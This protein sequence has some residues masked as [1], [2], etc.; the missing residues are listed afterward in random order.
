MKKSKKTLKM[1]I[2]C[3]ICIAAVVVINMVK[4]PSDPFQSSSNKLGY[5]HIEKE[6]LLNNP[7]EDGDSY[8]IYFY[9]VGCPYCEKV[10]DSIKT[11]ARSHSALYFV[12]MDEKSKDYKK[13]DWNKFHEENVLKLEK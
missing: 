11:Y 4:K 3:I 1:L 8:Y 9:K 5:E 2:I 12:N 13:F 7:K 6:E 10:E